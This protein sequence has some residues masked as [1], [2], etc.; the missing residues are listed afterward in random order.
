MSK[1]QLDSEPVALPAVAAMKI[2]QPI[3]LYL[4][5]MLQT[6]LFG[7]LFVYLL[8]DKQSSPPIPPGPQPSIV[9]TEDVEKITAEAER[10]FI[11]NKAEACE[12]LRAD[13]EGEKIKSSSQFASMAQTYQEAI[14]R[15]AF[16]GMIGLN[17]KYVAESGDKPW[18]AEQLAAIKELQTRK[19]AGYRSLLK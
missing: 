14:E 12:R 15:D 9:I 11:K 2:R 3:G 5:L 4:V 10:K 1:Y 6:L 8:L 17:Q 16:A 19:A 13:L 7:G 18:T